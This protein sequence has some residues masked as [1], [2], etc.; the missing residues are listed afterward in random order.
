[1]GEWCCGYVECLNWVISKNYDSITNIFSFVMELTTIGL[2]AVLVS[3]P[4]ER[5]VELVVI[6]AYATEL[7]CQ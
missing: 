3:A 5:D 6:Q 4:L 2:V 1:M 7:V